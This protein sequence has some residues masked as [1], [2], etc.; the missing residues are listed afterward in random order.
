MFG[1]IGNKRVEVNGLG[2]T[3]QNVLISP[4]GV[5]SKPNDEKA[6][7]TTYVNAVVGNATLYGNDSVDGG[8]GS[9]V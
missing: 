3:T 1:S 7:A 6:V 9:Y 8:V 5:Y 4:K 2:G